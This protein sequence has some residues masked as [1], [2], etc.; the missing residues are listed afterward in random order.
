MDTRTK[1]VIST[2]N[3][4][5]STPILAGGN[6]PTEALSPPSPPNT[7]IELASF[8]NAKPRTPAEALGLLQTRISE[9]QSM[10]EFKITLAGNPDTGK[11]YAVIEWRGKVLGLK[12][13]HILVNDVPVLKLE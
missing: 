1:L 2:G 12:D 5:S 6:V 13:G 7:S 3:G 10:K 4:A 11:L 9:M 8:L